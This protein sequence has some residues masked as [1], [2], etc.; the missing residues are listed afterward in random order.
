MS[1]ASFFQSFKQAGVAIALASLGLATSIAAFAA[2]RF[3]PAAPE[4]GTTI[5]HQQVKFGMRPFAD[6]TFYVIAMQKGWFNDVCI[7]IEPA[8]EGLKVNDTNATALLLNG[9]V[10]VISEN[11]P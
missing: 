10:D 8:P 7:G 4:A 9:Q 1:K 3:V 5:P 6:N 2:D 11:C